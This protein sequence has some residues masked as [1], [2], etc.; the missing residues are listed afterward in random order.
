MEN[1]LKGTYI[2]T[3]TYIHAHISAPGQEVGGSGEG[4]LVYVFYMLHINGYHCLSDHRDIGWFIWVATAGNY[5]LIRM[6]RG[7]GGGEWRRI[8]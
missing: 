1:I 5:I 7:K 4:R 8:L 2:H 3:H 6:Y